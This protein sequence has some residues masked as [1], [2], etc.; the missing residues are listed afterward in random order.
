[1]VMFGGIYFA[2]PRLVGK[3]WK[4]PGLLNLHFWV[5][6]IGIIIYAV[7]LGIGGY[8]Q[9]L[10]LQN[11]HGSF[12]ASV[13]VTRPYLIARSVGGTLMLLSHILMLYNVVSIIWFTK[14]NEEVRT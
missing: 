9:G 14:E 8:L 12:E 3:D 11:P 6:A 13:L 7:A 4:H 1:M 10:E 2:L 5:A